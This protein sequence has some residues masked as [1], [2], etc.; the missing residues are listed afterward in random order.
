MLCARAGLSTW[1]SSFLKVSISPNTLAVSAK[2]QRR[3]RHQAALAWPQAPGGRRGQA[4]A[5]T[6]SRRAACPGSSSV[7]TGG[8]SAPLDV[9]KRQ[10]TC[11]PAPA[12]RSMTCQ[13]NPWRSLPSAVQTHHRR[14]A[15]AVSACAQA[16]TCCGSSGS[17]ALRSQCASFSCPIHRALSA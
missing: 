6:S 2:R 13:R 17:G 7:C 4:R 14:R 3:R 16:M 12:H 9:K 5:P 8:R 11:P 10:A 15:R 1:A